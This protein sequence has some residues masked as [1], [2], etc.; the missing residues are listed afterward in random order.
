MSASP[1][2]LDLAA[3]A[4]WQA[5]AAVNDVAF[6]EYMSGSAIRPTC[7]VSSPSSTRTGRVP[8]VPSSRATTPKRPRRT[9][10]W[11]ASSASG[12]VR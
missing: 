2:R 7:G 3:A 1:T 11:R 4:A 10:S 5:V 6:A 12:G 8:Q 9:T